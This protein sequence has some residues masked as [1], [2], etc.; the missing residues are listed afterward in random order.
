MKYI[1]QLLLLTASAAL[2]CPTAITSH[3]FRPAYLSSLKYHKSDRDGDDKVILK[4]Q[5]VNAPIVRE[6]KTTSNTTDAD[7]ASVNAIILG[8]NAS[9]SSIGIFLLR[10][11][12]VV[13][14]LFI[15]ILP[16]T[17][18]SSILL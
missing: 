3:N 5:I 11:S 15:L 8:A 17:F 4:A 2:R 14:F 9:V 13:R 7:D 6:L 10:A 16:C 18:E 1:L 12:A